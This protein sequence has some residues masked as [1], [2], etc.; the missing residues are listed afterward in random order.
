[1]FFVDIDYFFWFFCTSK[2]SGQPFEAGPGGCLRGAMA[3][4]TG[5]VA[6]SFADATQNNLFK[7]SF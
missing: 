6:G 5:T 1:M 4:K 3:Q 2:T 7:D